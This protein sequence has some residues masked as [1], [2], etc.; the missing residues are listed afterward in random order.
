MQTG[1]RGEDLR[2]RSE[3][4]EGQGEQGSGQARWLRALKSISLRGRL[5]RRCATSPRSN[6][7]GP[8][9]VVVPVTALAP[10]SMLRSIVPWVLLTV[11][12]ATLASFVVHS[13]FPRIEYREMTTEHAASLLGFASGEEL[14]G[15]S[16]MRSER[17]G[18]VLEHSAFC[19]RCG[20]PTVKVRYYFPPA[21]LVGSPA[22]QQ[23]ARDKTWEKHFEAEPDPPVA[24]I[25]RR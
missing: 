4:G 13:F 23:M 20:F 18:D 24:T 12:T 17:A 14:Q 21:V 10:R 11:V 19:Q 8:R 2:G 15:F 6:S 1:R 9:F 25:A 22:W 5:P 3:V 7:S 16:L